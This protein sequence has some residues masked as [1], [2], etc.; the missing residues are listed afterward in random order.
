LVWAKVQQHKRSEL[1]GK[2]TFTK[3]SGTTW[4]HFA[5]LQLLPCTFENGF[6]PP[7]TLNVLS[8]LA[9]ESERFIAAIK[10]NDNF[11]FEEAATANQID[12]VAQ[13]KN[14]ST[15]TN[16]PSSSTTSEGEKVVG[17]LAKGGGALDD[18]VSALKT[19]FPSTW[20]FNKVGD[21]A[22]EV[23]D[24]VGNKWGTIYSDKIVAPARTA[25]GT[26]GNP[27]LNKVPLAK[28]IK[29]D[30]DG[31]I[32][33]TDD[34]GRVLE[35]NADLDDVMRVRLGNQQIRAVDVKDGV[36][37]VDQGGHI[38][39]SRFFGPGEQINLYPMTSNL[40]LSAW[41][42]MENVWADA[43]VAGKDVKIK[44]K[45]IYEGTSQRPIKFEVLYTIDGQPF[46]RTFDNL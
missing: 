2:T 21:D 42:Q 12:E 27:I 41:K 40:N 3:A 34:L 1:F 8:Q 17:S 44:V 39:G 31:L 25:V 29:Y 45:A 11:V 36:R 43:M 33:E 7:A 22:Y 28:K 19:D 10:R 23:F 4:L 46:K 18:I 30:V 15:H 13:A 16:L 20:K 14:G 24:G 9:D 5:S 26:P 35:T 38:V 6:R 37:G 32:Y